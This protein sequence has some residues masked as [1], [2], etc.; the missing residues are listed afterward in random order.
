[1]E[2]WAKDT[3]PA[4]AT[5]LIAPNVLRQDAVLGFER[6]SER[7]QVFAEKFGVA[8]I[9]SPSYHEYWARYCLPLR[10]AMTTETKMTIARNAGAKYLCVE[11]DPGLFNALHRDE[12]MCIYAVRIPH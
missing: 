6:V 2:H 8:V 3:L 5:F 10:S 9:W 1:M 12:G 11:C 7:S 4:D